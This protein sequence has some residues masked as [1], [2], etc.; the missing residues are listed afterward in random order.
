MPTVRVDCQSRARRW[1][2]AA[3]SSK[4]DAH[5]VGYYPDEV[6]AAEEAVKN[7][8]RDREEGSPNATMRKRAFPTSTGTVLANSNY[9]GDD[10]GYERQRLTRHARLR[11]SVDYDSQ[12]QRETESVE[13]ARANR[14]TVNN[15]GAI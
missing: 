15:A 10:D 12:R 7:R 6:R 5:W 4:G 13:E 3:G 11:V 14:Y 8:P 2:E 1:E 9:D